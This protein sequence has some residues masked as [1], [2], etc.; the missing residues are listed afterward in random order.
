M[1]GITEIRGGNMRRALAT[2]GNT[3]MADR[4]VIYEVGVVHVGGNP[5]R[6][7][8][9]VIAL[10]RCHNVRRRFTT[11]RHIVMATGTG[12]DNLGVIYRAGC[13]RRPRRYSCVVA[14]ITLIGSIDMVGRFT[15][16]RHAIV[17]TNTGSNQLRVIHRRRLY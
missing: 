1:A 15:G 5:C 8:M 16:C 6:G 4:T 9:A 3:I 2:G 7:G 13:D 17:A 10:L 11:G 12:A 14:G